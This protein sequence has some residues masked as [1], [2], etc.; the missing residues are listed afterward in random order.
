MYVCYLYVVN[1]DEYKDTD[2]W[3]ISNINALFRRPA[4]FDYLHVLSDVYQKSNYKLQTVN[5]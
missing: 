2:C 4:R 5:V 3:V 1:K